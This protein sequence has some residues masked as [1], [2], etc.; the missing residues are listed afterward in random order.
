M[1]DSV[2]K[3]PTDWGY[4]HA[5][6][7]DVSGDVMLA[8]RNSLRDL[9][10]V[11]SGSLAN[12]D[13][14][15]DTVKR[16]LV[17]LKGTG[18]TSALAHKA[19]D[20]HIKRNIVPSYPPLL[21]RLDNLN[22]KLPPPSTMEPEE[23]GPKITQ[24]SNTD[25]W[26]AAWQFSACI[27]F[28]ADCLLSPSKL[29][30]QSHSAEDNSSAGFC[31]ILQR[32][33]KLDK[34]SREYICFDA[35][36][37]I[38][39]LGEHKRRIPNLAKSDLV[40]KVIQQLINMRAER[41]EIES[42]LTQ[43][44]YDECSEHLQLVQTTP[45][46][47]FIDAIDEAVQGLRLIQYGD[48][49]FGRDAWDAIQNGF[50]GAII[51]M[52][53]RTQDQLRI[54]GVIRKEAYEKYNLNDTQDISQ[55][56]EISVSM[57]YT[58]TELENIFIENV[59]N[60][61]SHYLVSSNNDGDHMA[62]FFPTKEFS[63]PHAFGKVE[64]PF[65]W[66]LRHTFN[67]PRQIVWHGLEILKKLPDPASR[68]TRAELGKVINATGEKIFRNYKNQILWPCELDRAILEIRSNVVSK[69]QMLDLR[70]RYPD[71]HPIQ[72][73]YQKGLVGIRRGANGDGFYQNFLEAGDHDSEMLP[74]S[75]FYVIHPCLT[76]YLETKV[77]HEIQANFVSRLF[78]V[79][80]G[81]ACPANNSPRI[82]L[83]KK[84]NLGEIGVAFFPDGIQCSDSIE[85]NEIYEINESKLWF[86]FFIS[87]ILCMK[88]GIKDRNW[89]SV[90]TIVEQVRELV[91]EQLL[92]PVFG[93]TPSGELQKLTTDEY[94]RRTISK[95]SLAKKGPYWDDLKVFFETSF[96]ALGMTVLHKDLGNNFFDYSIRNFDA[97]NIQILI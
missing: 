55:L 10:L 49:R 59:K 27:T 14:D 69:N 9:P 11:T 73:L 90:D 24:Y 60:T 65:N 91:S 79:G 94:V 19:A 34:N 44:L 64:K 17:G 8:N 3:K 95:K 40:F 29:I 75:P 93:N 22:L 72:I 35:L 54:F 28:L 97:D 32:Q 56:Q 86:P 85:G 82:I 46:G 70:D 89:V 38:T 31:K 83:F 1:T 96:G 43:Y 2:G 37:R 81:L 84:V 45:V 5:W 15:I 12:Y 63:V 21:C 67:N 71:L 4:N 68:A 66:L 78:I 33:S 25:F 7:I 53:I 58:K 16:V 36:D 6:K 77:P 20:F 51:A 47:I 50:L 26:T 92:P 61:Y 39:W 23:L 13:G 76:G 80:D 74:D 42:W 30:M 52:R 41:F 18:K 48:Y 87:L 88:K 62:K 57:E